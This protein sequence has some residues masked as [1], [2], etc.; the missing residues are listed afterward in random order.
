MLK[1]PPAT[2]RLQAV[3]TLA[4]Q[5]LDHAETLTANLE[6]AAFAT[7]LHAINVAGRQRML[8]QRLAKEALMQTLAPNQSGAPTP[9]LGEFNAGLDYLHR[10]AL[11]NAEI[12]RELAA[13]DLATQQF[14]RCLADQSTPASRASMADSSETLLGH[15]DASP[16]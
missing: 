4:E 6:V 16:L 14:Q 10:L 3:D 11:T 7:A 5:V 13:T 2:S 9:T 15:F 8:T 1:S 12:T